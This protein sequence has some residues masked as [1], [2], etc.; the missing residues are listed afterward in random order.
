MKLTDQAKKELLVFSKTDEFKY[1]KKHIFAENP[2]TPQ[3]TNQFTDF[4]QFLH[5]MADHPVRPHKP[6]KGDFKL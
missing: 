5:N 2:G 1:L 6:M 3:A 4:I